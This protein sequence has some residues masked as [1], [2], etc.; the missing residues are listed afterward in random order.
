MIDVPQFY[1]T[2]VGPVV[3]FFPILAIPI[4]WFGLV[5]AGFSPKARTRGLS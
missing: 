2:N 1:Q 4:L 3:R 5:R